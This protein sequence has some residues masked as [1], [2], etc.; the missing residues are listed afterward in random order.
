MTWIVEL[1]G[2]QHSLCELEASCRGEGP[3]VLVSGHYRLDSAL[4][5]QVDDYESAET[6]AQ[7]EVGYLN[8]YARLFLATHWKIAVG[9]ISRE[10]PDKPKV[11]YATITDG[12]VVSARL[13]GIRLGDD[14][15]VFQEPDLGPGLRAWRALVQEEQ[16]VADVQQY[17]R[18]PLDDWSNLGRIIEAIEH[19]AGGIDKLIATGWIDARSLKRFHATAN[20]PLVAGV[21]ARHGARKYKAPGSPMDTHEAQSLITGIARKWIIAKIGAT[22]G[23]SD[24]PPL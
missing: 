8:G 11:H 13:V 23:A 10:E 17:L 21:T 7:R 5:A 24:V 16:V 4:F 15:G 19:D 12:L 3:I 1:N 9:N 14:E 22:A 2:D 20:N 6:I 18:G